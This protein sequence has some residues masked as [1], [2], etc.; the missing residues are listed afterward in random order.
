VAADRKCSER[1]ARF[2]ATA[3]DKVDEIGIDKEAREG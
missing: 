3:T 2:F 1:G